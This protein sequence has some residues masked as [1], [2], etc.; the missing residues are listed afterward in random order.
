MINVKQGETAP[1]SI[2]YTP[3]RTLITLTQCD[4]DDEEIR[5]MDLL[6]QVM[7]GDH[8]ETELGQDAQNR[9]AE[10]FDNRYWER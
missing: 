10:W 7:E 8:I 2:T 4:S 3:D 6:S 9:I 5:R 1:G